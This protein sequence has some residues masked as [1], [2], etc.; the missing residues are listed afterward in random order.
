MRDGSLSACVTKR[1]NR[2]SVQKFGGVERIDVG[3]KLL[4]QR[5]G[6]VGL[7][8]DSRDFGEPLL[9]RSEAAL[10][11]ALGVHVGRV[12]IGDHPLRR[13]RGRFAGAR[14][15]DEVRVALLRLLKDLEAHARARTIGRYFGRLAPAAIGIFVEVVARFYGEIAQGEVDSDRLCWRW[16]G[17]AA[18]NIG[19]ANAISAIDPRTCI[20]MRPD[21]QRSLL[22]NKPDVSLGHKGTPVLQP[23][24]L[25]GK[26]SALS[27]GSEDR[28][29]TIPGAPQV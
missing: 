18:N 8:F 29:E 14:F 11:D 25:S 28:E 3:A 17:E 6:E 27:N 2:F 16:C 1:P 20:F 22:K 12:I 26:V 10:L 19:A 4:A 15:A 23:P 21:W 24:Q 5:A 9:E 7:R 13:A